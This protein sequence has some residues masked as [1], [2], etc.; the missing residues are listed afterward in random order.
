MKLTSKTGDI[1]GA[2]ITE[3]D[4]DLMALTSKGKMIRVG[5]DAIRK[6]GR[7][8]TGVKIINLNDNDKLIDIE[9]CMKEEKGEEIE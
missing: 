9:K 3:D 4:M 8:T 7:N 2:I 5:I 1:V 6:A